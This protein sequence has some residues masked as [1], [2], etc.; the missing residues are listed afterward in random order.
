LHR[1]DDPPGSGLGLA[2]CV[3]IA[4]AHGGRLDI[5]AAL[6]GGTTVTIRLPASAPAAI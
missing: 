1:D 3:R 2:T 5:G 6:D 4:N